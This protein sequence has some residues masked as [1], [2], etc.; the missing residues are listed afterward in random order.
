MSPELEKDIKRLL[1]L[2]NNDKKESK[3]VKS[4]N[5]TKALNKIIKEKRE[6][7][8]L[9]LQNVYM[10]KIVV[11]GE[12]I[13]NIQCIKSQIFEKNISLLTY[14]CKDLI[15]TLFNLY[16]FYDKKLLDIASVIRNQLNIKDFEETKD[17]IKEYDIDELN[18]ATLLY[19]LS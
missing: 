3:R 10:G 7:K 14:K 13:K 8:I 12:P 2:T 17:D 6:N 16:D 4:L 19:N 18:P 5:Q 9:H 11:S 1:A 15:N